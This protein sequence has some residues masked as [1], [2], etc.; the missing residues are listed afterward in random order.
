M[1]FPVV[2]L[3]I[4]S[5]G[6][7]LFARVHRRRYTGFVVAPIPRSF[8]HYFSGMQA[9]LAV[10]HESVR[11]AGLPMTILQE[12]KFIRNSTVGLQGKQGHSSSRV[13]TTSVRF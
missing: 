4:Y 10:N 12:A 8:K 1:Y 6:I 13:G 5:T 11:G 2:V 7:G 3:L 9:A